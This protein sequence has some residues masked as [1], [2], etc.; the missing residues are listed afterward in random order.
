MKE[1]NVP[2]M[3]YNGYPVGMDFTHPIEAVVPGVQGRVLAVLVETTAELNLRTI[4]RLAGASAAQAS[5]VLPPLVDL[6]LVER[7]EVPPASLFRL[8]PDHVAVGPLLALARARDAVVQEMAIAAEKLSVV[9]ESVIVFGSFARGEADLS[10]DIDVLFV[11]PAESDEFDE[12]WADSIQQWKDAIHRVTGNRVEVL[13][14]GTGEIGKR[15]ASRQ[16]L[17]SDIGR[18]GLVV[19]GMSIDELRQRANA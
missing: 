6:G 7:R 11:R 9:P 13:E 1:T 12:E 2:F 14:A 8:V 17:W 18:D 3:P 4:A 15:L 19:H 16:P 5:R 10:S